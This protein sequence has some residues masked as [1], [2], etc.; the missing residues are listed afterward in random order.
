MTGSK[1]TCVVG[2]SGYVGSAVAAR[3]ALDGDS[4]VGTH[5]SNPTPGARTRFD[6]WSDDPERIGDADGVVFASTVERDDRPFEAFDRR[7]DALTDACSGG[8][9]V[10]VSS[11]AVFD[12]ESGPYAEDAP[13][14]PIHR[15]GRRTARFETLVASNCSDY[16]IVRPSY[17]YGYSGGVLDRR[18]SRTFRSLRSGERVAYWDDYVRSPVEVNQFA[19]IVRRVYASDVRG[20]IHAGGPRVSA[21]QFHRRAARAF[22]APEG[23]IESTGMPPQCSHPADT[24]LDSGRLSEEFGLRPGSVVESLTCRSVDD[25]LD[26]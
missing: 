20:V 8:R 10:Y 16:C 11:D 21:Y 14:N 17:V 24:S 7:A 25:V 18:L 22:G 5:R 13:T 9:F 2:A 26:G 12:G 4:V 3:L 15:Y 19:E 1:D 6:F 23:R